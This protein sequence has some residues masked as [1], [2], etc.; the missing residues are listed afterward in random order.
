MTT[1]AVSSVVESALANFQYGVPPHEEIC[2]L[3]VTTERPRNP[4]ENLL[5]YRRP[6]QTWRS[7]A[8]TSYNIIELANMASV[9]ALLVGDNNL[10]YYFLR[11]RLTPTG[12]WELAGPNIIGGSQDLSSAP[13][14]WVTAS[15]SVAASTEKGPHPPAVATQLTLGT[16]GGRYN[17][18]GLTFTN[19]TSNNRTFTASCWLKGIG[20]S[21][22]RTLALV[23]DQGSTA[24]SQV[25]YTNVTLTNQWALYSFTG[26]LDEN[27]KTEVRFGINRDLGSSNIGTNPFLVYSCQLTPDVSTFV[28]V[29]YYTFWYATSSEIWNSMYADP[30]TGRKKALLRFKES[31]AN[32]PY[33]QLQIPDVNA[34][35]DGT[36]WWIGSLLGNSDFQTFPD[37]Q[38]WPITA[39]V[40][41]ATKNVKLESGGHETL[42]LGERNVRLVLGEGVHRTQQS[43]A[44]A[45]SLASLGP[46]SEILIA[47]NRPWPGGGPGAIDEPESQAYIVRKVLSPAKS[48]FV[49]PEV[50]QT[51][52]AF[53]E[54]L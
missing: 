33:V 25:I 27:A 39:T 9:E 34:P 28:G 7:I 53:E 2:I 16:G 30:R 29:M 20:T 40:T 49:M 12:T 32:Y 50:M 17:E 42:Q 38:Q 26:T 11:K 43:E 15:G 8:N 48:S 51:G 22:G 41:E 45:N 54:I 4:R 1:T 10:R 13:W 37:K 21:V 35:L 5:N 6:R 23:V 31:L 24:P 47:E 18:T 36:D 3:D 19:G 44:A 14:V 46:T 52:F